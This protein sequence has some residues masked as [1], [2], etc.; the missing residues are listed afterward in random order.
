MLANL[1]KSSLIIPSPIYKVAA[2]SAC[3]TSQ[4]VFRPVS[5]TKHFAPG[6][7]DT[8]VYYCVFT[9]IGETNNK[10]DDYFV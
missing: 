9:F 8:H 1:K 5:E 2:F 7:R 4:Q 10:V 6:E 3:S